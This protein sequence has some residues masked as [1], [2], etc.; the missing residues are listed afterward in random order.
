M[1]N[2]ELEKIEV[3][4]LCSRIVD[5]DGEPRMRDLDLAAVLEFK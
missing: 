1:N 5:Y 2:E 4:Q 3:E